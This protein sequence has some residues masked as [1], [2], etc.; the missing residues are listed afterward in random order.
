MFIQVTFEDGGKEYIYKSPINIAPG[1]IVLV[2]T[3][4]N[5]RAA[6]VVRECIN[7]FE[8]TVKS[9]VGIGYLLEDLDLS[10]AE[11]KANSFFSKLLSY[12]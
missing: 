12:I 8:G 6:K 1:Q 5:I 9:I 2:N 7:T 4:G 10:Q 11:V 3:Y